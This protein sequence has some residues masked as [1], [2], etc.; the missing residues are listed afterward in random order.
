MEFMVIILFNW[1]L[2]M[3]HLIFSINIYAKVGNYKFILITSNTK[4][5]EDL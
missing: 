4:L 1:T 3:L 2:N 5:M